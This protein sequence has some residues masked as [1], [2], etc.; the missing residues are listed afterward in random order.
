[1][2]V[3]KR[4]DDNFYHQPVVHPNNLFLRRREI[5]PSKTDAALDFYRGKLEYDA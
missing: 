1:M 2:L 3:V 5:A 4:S